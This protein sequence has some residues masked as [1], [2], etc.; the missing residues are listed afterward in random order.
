MEL[1]VIFSKNNYSDDLKIK[2]DI[3]IIEY[4]IKKEG[5]FSRE[6]LILST[7]E[8][9]K[10]KLRSKK[11][12]SLNLL[13]V[14]FSKNMSV[15]R[16]LIGYLNILGIRHTKQNFK[17]TSGINFY[18]LGSDDNIFTDEA[19]LVL[20]LLDGEKNAT[21]PYEDNL[22]S[23]PSCPKIISPSRNGNSNYLYV[24]IKSISKINY[25]SAGRTH[26]IK[27]S[28][29]PSHKTKNKDGNEKVKHSKS[30]KTPQK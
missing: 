10:M 2:N 26:N 23:P 6:N 13:V 17:I 12:E 30:V 9:Q 4:S 21:D 27:V 8:I 7:E 19:I 25:M 3:F 29:R 1:A 18:A 28:K 20:Y 15:S 11:N 22:P 16:D 14:S 24:P 5:I